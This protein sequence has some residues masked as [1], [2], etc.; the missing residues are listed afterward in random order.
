MPLAAPRNEIDGS[1]KV[2]CKNCEH[3][4]ENNNDWDVRFES[5]PDD[6]KDRRAPAGGSLTRLLIQVL[7]TGTDSKPLYHTP[8]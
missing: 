7:T 6:T 5:W 3:G 1:K 8:S 4:G 2:M